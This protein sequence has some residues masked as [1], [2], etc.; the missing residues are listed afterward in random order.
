[1]LGGG[2][3]A[4]QATADQIH[5]EVS[6][7]FI[8]ASYPTS[9]MFII[10]SIT[11]ETVMLSAV[12]PYPISI[13]C[14]THPHT[15]RTCHSVTWINENPTTCM[16]EYSVSFT[17][18]PTRKFSYSS[19]GFQS[20]CSNSIVPAAMKH[21]ILQLACK[22]TGFLASSHL[23]FQLCLIPESVSLIIKSTLCLIFYESSLKQ[24]RTQA[25]KISFLCHTFLQFFLNV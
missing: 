9:P 18:T 23:T 24:K 8:R 12:I 6:A 1:M 3:G 21:K 25:L 22:S 11:R 17:L 13:I 10:R 7:C 2:G 20:I 4:N 15:L 14:S 16:A 19:C 5:R